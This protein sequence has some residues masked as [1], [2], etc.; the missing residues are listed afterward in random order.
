[1]SPI[2]SVSVFS[3]SFLS[4]VCTTQILIGLSFHFMSK[5]GKLLVFFSIHFSTLHIV[6]TRP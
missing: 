4:F 1:M 3:F 5:I 6:K 2:F